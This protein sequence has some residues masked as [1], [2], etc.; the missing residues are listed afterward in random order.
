MYISSQIPFTH[1]EWLPL[2]TVIFGDSDS[3]LLGIFIIDE[4]CLNWSCLRVLLSTDGLNHL[5][6]EGGHTPVTKVLHKELLLS[7]HGSA[8]Q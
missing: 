6:Q 1:L 7:S 3:P 2:A 8:P 5:F 4:G